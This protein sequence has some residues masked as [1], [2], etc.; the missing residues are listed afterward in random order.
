MK[1]R[2][3]RLAA[4]AA[5]LAGAWA[6]ADVL[7]RD[8]ASDDEIHAKAALIAQSA[9]HRTR[10]DRA[11]ARALIAQGDAAYRAGRY[12]EAHGDYDN[13]AANAPSAYAYIMT[14]DSH[15]RAALA[16]ARQPATAGEASTCRLQRLHFVDDLRLDLNQQYLIGL[17]LAQVTTLVPRPDPALRARAKASAACLARLAQDYEPLPPQTCVEA[18]RI[19]RCLGPPLVK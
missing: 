11:A 6:C 14:G 13:A 10:A 12:D 5:F 7:A 18:T 8:L 15:W 17:R 16:S 3:L 19:A 9:R 1:G 4:A 2:T